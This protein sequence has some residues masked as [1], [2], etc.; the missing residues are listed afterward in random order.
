MCWHGIT[1]ICLAQ[2]STWTWTVVDR[3]RFWCSNTTMTFLTNSLEVIVKSS[4]LMLDV[5]VVR[6]ADLKKGKSSFGPKQIGARTQCLRWCLINFRLNSRFCVTMCCCPTTISSWRSMKDVILAPDWWVS[7]A[8]LVSKECNHGINSKLWAVLF[9]LHLLNRDLTCSNK[10]VFDTYGHSQR[11]GGTSRLCHTFLSS[12]MKV[13]SSGWIKSDGNE[14]NDS[15]WLRNTLYLWRR[16]LAFS[17]ITHT[18]MLTADAVSHTHFHTS[19]PA[20]AVALTRLCVIDVCVCVP[21]VSADVY[22]P[23]SSAKCLQLSARKPPAYGAAT[24]GY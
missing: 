22:F 20:A 17:L 14:S 13:T 23:F 8:G 18:Q 15:R 24:A 12:Q 5:S 3:I 7:P 11:T 16:L 9:L 1:E 21:A 10:Q 2:T 6:S 4:I 19:S